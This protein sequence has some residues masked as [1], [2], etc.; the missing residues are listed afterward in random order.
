MSFETAIHRRPQTE[1]HKKQ[2]F[3]TVDSAGQGMETR[4]A[5]TGT[6]NGVLARHSDATLGVTDYPAIS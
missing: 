1:P 2:G 6:V 5:G 4:Q 3:N